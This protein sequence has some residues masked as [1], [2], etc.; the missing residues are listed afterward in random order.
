M[1]PAWAMTRFVASPLLP[2]SMAHVMSKSMMNV[3]YCMVSAKPL[4][5]PPI[6]KERTQRANIQ[7]DLKPRGWTAMHINVTTNARF[8]M[9]EM[10]IPIAISYIQHISFAKSTAILIVTHHYQ[11][12]SPV[13]N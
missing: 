1:T 4:D 10:I 7:L 11:R 12:L 3:G 8:P 2:A 9:Q 13:N 5:R 6:A